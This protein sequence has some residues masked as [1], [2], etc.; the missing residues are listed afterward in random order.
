MQV[1]KLCSAVA[2]L[3][4]GVGL[5]GV[6]QDSRTITG[7]FNTINIQVP[8]TSRIEGLELRFSGLGYSDCVEFTWQAWGEAPRL[9]VDAGDVCI[10]WLSATEGGRFPDSIRFGFG[11]YPYGPCREVRGVTAYGI[12]SGQLRILG[13]A[14]VQVWEV[15]NGGLQLVD[16]ILAPLPTLMNREPLRVE[17]WEFALLAEPL[18][19][20]ALASDRIDDLVRQ[21]SDK[22]WQGQEM[23]EVIPGEPLRL[24][25]D[26]SPEAR[27]VVVRYSTSVRSELGDTIS[28]RF[29]NEAILSP[30]HP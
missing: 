11:L 17:K 24:P 19:L 29:V 27:A 21:Y 18:T 13:P 30:A 23:L 14:P 5:L 6:P 16:I 7:T 26:V 22:G 15:V 20:E 3:V 4:L 12:E 1:T 2:L 10:R 25:I 9:I 28:M 8:P